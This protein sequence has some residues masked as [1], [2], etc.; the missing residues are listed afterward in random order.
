MFAPPF[1]PASGGAPQGQSGVPF[2]PQNSNAPSGPF[3]PRSFL[4]KFA[5]TQ[6][7][8]YPKPSF[9]PPQGYSNTSQT[10]N[11]PNYSQPSHPQP[12]PFPPAL[13]STAPSQQH[14]GGPPTMNGVP[15]AGSHSSS[16]QG[17]QAPANGFAPHSG[18]SFQSPQQAASATSQSN[19]P[20]PQAAQSRPAPFPPQPVQSFP[21]TNHAPQQSYGIGAHQ[22]HS[23]QGYPQTSAFQPPQVS[24]QQPAGAQA[25][26]GGSFF[27]QIPS[28]DGHG[29]TA[30]SGAGGPPPPQNSGFAAPGPAGQSHFGSGPPSMPGSFPPGS[31]GAGRGMPGA[32]PPGMPGGGPPGIPGVGPP[33]MSGVGHPG[34]PGAGPPT[35]PGMPNMGH[36]GMPGS[37][38]PGMQSGGPPGM[39][40]AGPPGMPSGGPP[41]M[42]GAGPPGMPG[43]SQGPGMPPGGPSMQPRQ[44]QPQPQ[45]RLDPNMMPSARPA[46]IIDLGPG[47]PVRCQRCKAYMCPFM[48][49]QDGGRRFRCPFCHASTP[50]SAGHSRG[51]IASRCYYSR[52]GRM[53]S[54]KGLIIAVI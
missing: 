42:L 53:L 46:P 6:F 18:A 29:S 17:H 41:G 51:Q 38:H 50:G 19:G 31:S 20:A 4:W 48:E 36:Q 28:M 44:P 43:F 47:G 45:Q 16:H 34:M 8:G 15:G 3:Q 54:Q 11:M 7:G 33:G 30:F 24:Q 49:F 12:K 32:A 13:N 27:S 2:P 10:E 37:G 26:P 21:S 35:M 14:H 25:A 9:D 40:G 22:N 1:P 23:N 52:S 39:L 5:H